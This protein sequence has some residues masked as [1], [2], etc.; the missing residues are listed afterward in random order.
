MALDKSTLTTTIKNALK[1]NVNQADADAAAK[2]AAE[3]A[4]DTLATA[5]ANAIDAFVKSGTVSFTPGQVTGYCPANAALTT[6][7]ASGGMI[8]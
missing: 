5:I 4:A 6:G 7:A 3:S 8:E 1:A 2:A